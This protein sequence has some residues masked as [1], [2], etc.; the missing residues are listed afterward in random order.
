[1]RPSEHLTSVFTVTYTTTVLFPI[2]VFLEQPQRTEISL[3]SAEKKRK[4]KKK[5]KKKMLDYI[6]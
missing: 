3:Q 1:M 5:K 4:K 2:I 6:W